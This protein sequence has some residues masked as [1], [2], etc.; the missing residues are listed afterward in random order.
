[1][2]KIALIYA[3]G[4]INTGKSS[5]DPGRGSMGSETVVKH[6]SRPRPDKTVKAIVLRVDSPAGR[7]WPAT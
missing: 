7:P 1:M 6:L 3:S 2:P 4:A 5:V